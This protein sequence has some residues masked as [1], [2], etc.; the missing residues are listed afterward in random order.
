MSEHIPLPLSTTERMENGLN[1]NEIYSK[2]RRR[3]EKE[4]KNAALWGNSLRFKLS[5]IIKLIWFLTRF[6]F[7]ISL[8]ND[9]EK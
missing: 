5:K 4:L 7:L 9:D 3:R 1:R 8:M 6:R 2:G